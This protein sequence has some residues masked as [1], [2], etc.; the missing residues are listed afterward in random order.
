MST[1][2]DVVTVTC[3]VGLVIAFF[4]FTSRDTRILKHFVLAGVVFAVANQV[5]N[6]GSGILATILIVAGI[7]YAV[8][9]T[10]RANS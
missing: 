6:H 2:F 8:L 1:L 9:I 3:F 4:Q 5:G 7:A 10:I